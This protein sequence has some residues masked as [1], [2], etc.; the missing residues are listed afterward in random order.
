[1]PDGWTGWMAAVALPAA[2]LAA[3]GLMGP[4]PG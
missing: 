3:A 4:A 2:A 1:M